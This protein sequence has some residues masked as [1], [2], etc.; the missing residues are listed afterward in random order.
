MARPI[1]KY[2]PAIASEIQRLRAQGVSVK[3]ISSL[4]EI[5]ERSARRIYKNELEK[6]KSQ[7]NAAIVGKLF[8][9]AM[10]GNATCL[11]FWAKTQL[12]WK[13]KQNEQG[14]DIEALK[15]GLASAFDSVGNGGQACGVLVTP[16]LMSEE[17][18]QKEADQYAQGRQEEK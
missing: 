1:K 13:E 8:E 4:V 7:A 2:D 12:G 10:Q 18:W 11:I 5:S 3:D 16:G 15:R 14:A 9:M 6:G 17:Q